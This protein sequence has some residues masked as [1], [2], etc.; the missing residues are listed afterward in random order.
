[1]KIQALKTRQKVERPE[2]VRTRTEL[3]AMKT[4]GMRMKPERPGSL[5]TAGMGPEAERPVMEPKGNPKTER[6]GT[7]R[8]WMTPEHSGGLKMAGMKPETRRLG[9]VRLRMELRRKLE[10]EWPKMTRLWIEPG[11]KQKT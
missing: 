10:M 11:R 2:T 7:V 9:M 4:T 3:E 5:R 1:M 6:P 8:M